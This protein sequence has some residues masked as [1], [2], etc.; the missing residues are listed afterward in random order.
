[1]T[2]IGCLIIANLI[3]LLVAFIKGEKPKFIS[4]KRILVTLRKLKNDTMKEKMKAFYT[5]YIQFV[6]A[7]SVIVYGIIDR[8]VLLFIT[9]CCL[10]F[11]FAVYFIVE[12]D[13]VAKLEH[14][15]RETTYRLSW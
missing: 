7:I 1:M 6:V 4:P 5:L 14:I 15:I 13:I 8:C 11:V 10:T 2:I 9:L 12:H 3:A